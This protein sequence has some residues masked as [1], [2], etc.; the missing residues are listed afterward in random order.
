MVVPNYH[1][2]VIEAIYIKHLYTF[3]ANSSCLIFWFSISTS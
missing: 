1:V 3:D 2:P